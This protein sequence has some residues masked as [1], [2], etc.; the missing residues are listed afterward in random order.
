[1]WLFTKCGFFSAVQNSKDP[2]L[3]HVRAR[4]KGDLESLLKTHR[5]LVGRPAPK[6]MFTLSC[7]YRYRTDLPRETFAAIVA[8]EAAAINYT[9]FK[10]RVHDGTV[11]DRAYMDVWCAMR[12][13]QTAQHGYGRCS[14]K[15]LWLVD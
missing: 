13:A 6:A 14:P 9:N 11:R 5:K 4:F 3:I 2:S 10:N 8:A 15:G 12:R 1:M 7:D